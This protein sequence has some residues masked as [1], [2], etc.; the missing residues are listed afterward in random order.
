MISQQK[1]MMK[2]EMKI[3]SQVISH[4]SITYQQSHQ[5]LSIWPRRRITVFFKGIKSKQ[6]A[7]SLDNVITYRLKNS[8][9]SRIWLMEHKFNLLS[10]F[11]KWKISKIEGLKKGS[12][13]IVKCIEILMEKI[14]RMI[15]RSSMKLLFLKIHY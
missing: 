3:M 4:S 11:Q 14:V 6:L 1:K 5:N 12:K 9:E 8:R 7:S 10:F 13:F 2:M 15:L